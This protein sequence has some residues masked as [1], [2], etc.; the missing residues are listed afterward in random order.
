F[1]RGR[2]KRAKERWT[3]RA[4]ALFWFARSPPVEKESPRESWTI[5]GP[6]RK[7]HGCATRQKGRGLHAPRSV[8]PG[9]RKPVSFHA[10]SRRGFSDELD[11]VENRAAHARARQELR[12]AQYR[13]PRAR[14]RVL[15]DPRRLP[16]QRA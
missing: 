2:P 12:A 10:A 13:R 16:A 14:D 5:V 1:A 3:R 7:R 4:R 6:P 8:A 11:G 9:G 15:L